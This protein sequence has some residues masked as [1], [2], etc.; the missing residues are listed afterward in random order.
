[1]AE[2]VIYDFGA[3]RCRTPGVIAVDINPATA[4]DILADVTKPIGRIPAGSADE[5]WCCS[6]LEHLPYPAHFDALREMLRVLK[7]GG[8]CVLK[9]PHP[10]QDSSMVPGHVHVL[11]PHYWRTIQANPVCAGGYRL[12]IRSITETPAPTLAERC[13]RLGLTVEEGLSCLR[14]AAIEVVVVGAKEEKP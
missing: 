12:A 11:P 9:V 7:V 14:N 4:P 2:R 1:V 10:S 6:V 13:A 8:K 3:G 5:V